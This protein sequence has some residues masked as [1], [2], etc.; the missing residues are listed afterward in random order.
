MQQIDEAGFDKLRLW[1]GCGHP[2]DRL[3]GKKHGAFR[4]RVDIAGEA[5]RAQPGKEVVG[6]MAEPADCSD[7]VRAEGDGFEK[8]QG[9]IEP[10]RDQKVATRR[11]PAKKQLEHRDPGQP[12]FEIRGHHVQLVEIGQQRLAGRRHQSTPVVSSGRRQVLARGGVQSHLIGLGA[13]QLIGVRC[14]PG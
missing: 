12:G 11:Q 5:K 10:C 3:V 8:V 6:E 9:L 2:D 1:Q 7:I 13:W 4:H 14:G